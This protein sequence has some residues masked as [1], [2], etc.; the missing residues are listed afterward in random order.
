MDQDTV[1]R[2]LQAQAKTESAATLSQH[3][4]HFTGTE[5]YY[6]ISQRYLITDGV[7]YLADQAQAYWMVDAV[8]SHLHEIGTNDWFV[9][10]KAQVKDSAAL[11]LYEDGNGRELARQFIPFTD[12]PLD[13]ISLY[14]CWDS[15]HWVIMLPSEY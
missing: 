2:I 13:S 14:A 1:R 3:L 6:R 5:K 7:K 12:F 11:M 10:V 9:L 4:T 15:E 8:V